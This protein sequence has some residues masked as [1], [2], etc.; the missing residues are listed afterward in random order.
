MDFIFWI[1]CAI[2]FILGFV[3]ARKD[4]QE[5]LIP[6]KYTHLGIFIGV[7]INFIVHTFSFTFYLYFSIL[8]LFYLAFMY[9]QRAIHL[10]GS[11]LGTG[12]IKYFL[13]IYALL[14]FNLS[15]FAGI[16][17]LSVIFWTIVISVFM[18]FYKFFYFSILS[19]IAIFRKLYGSAI[20]D[21][22]LRLAPIIFMSFIIVFIMMI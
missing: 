10:N 19:R 2:I 5:G 17:L 1:S 8:V 20:E 7:G 14:P 6:N 16:P 3:C 18:A 4:S 11:T 15:V 12:D 21:N 9:L 13:M 22:S